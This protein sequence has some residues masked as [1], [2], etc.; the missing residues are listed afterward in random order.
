M[1]T[2]RDARRRT[3]VPRIAVFAILGLLAAGLAGANLV[4]PPRLSTVDANSSL[5]ISRT[6]QRVQLH[7]SQPIDPVAPSSVTVA[8]STPID[9]A[10]DGSALT[11]RFLEMLD[12]GTEYRIEARVRGAATG[13]DGTVSA[14]V[15]TPD[16]VTYTLS[17][18]EEGD[19]LLGHRLQQP[20]ATHT[21]FSA[22]HIQEYASTAAGLAVITRDDT[23]HAALAIHSESTRGDSGP[24]F[25]A[26]DPF[27]IMSSGH[28]GQL[29]SETN[30]GV[31]GVVASGVGDDS[32]EYD[33]TL[34]VIDP[35]TVI[36]STVVAP[37]GSAMP[38]RDWRF[39]PGTTSLVYQ[40]PDGRLFGWEAAPDPRSFDLGVSGDLLGFIPGTTMLAIGDES[41][42]S[43]IDLS[44]VVTGTLDATPPRTPVAAPAD[45]DP[46]ALIALPPDAS[47]ARVAPPESELLPAPAA[48]DS[49]STG[50]ALGDG[51]LVVNGSV[52]V[53]ESGVTRTIF[54]PAAETTRVGRVCLSPNAEYAAIETISSE[55]EPDGRPVAPGFTQTTTNYVR[56]DTGETT[57]SAVGGISDWCG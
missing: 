39:I 30:S 46:R 8:P 32:T 7:L 15:R 34:L 10:S 12:T 18:S 23:G 17:R 29:R 43:L 42:A 13:S 51:S 2:E 49:R 4:Q 25:A 11:I 36:V 22:P 24:G 27:R 16:P 20:G 14:V 31:I 53:H 33:R 44:G 28:L 3:L 6:D 40:S 57:R 37:D 45:S 54:T 52:V 38:V 21:A 5:L 48:V 50:S 35:A 55:G 1:Y 9:V 56:I 47:L 19:R 41:G 26:T